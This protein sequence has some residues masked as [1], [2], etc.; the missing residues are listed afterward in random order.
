MI[1]Q[2]A[3]RPLGVIWE[4]FGSDQ[5]RMVN[6]FDKKQIFLLEEMNNTK[7]VEEYL[8]DKLPSIVQNTIDPN[9]GQ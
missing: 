5:N 9:T 6:T 2:Y 1:P 7:V 8:E 3:E 4:N